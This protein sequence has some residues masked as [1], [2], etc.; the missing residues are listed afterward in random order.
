MKCVRGRNLLCRKKFGWLENESLFSSF[1]LDV[2]DDDDGDVYEEEAVTNENN[3]QEQFQ[4]QSTGYDKNYVLVH[5][6]IDY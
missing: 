2:N 6:R 4:V 5:T 3:D 1:S